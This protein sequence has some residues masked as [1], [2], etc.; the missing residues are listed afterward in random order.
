MI[1]RAMRLAALG[2]TVVAVACAPVE[3]VPSDG[4]LFDTGMLGPVDADGDGFAGADDCD[5]GDASVSPA[6]TAFVSSKVR[7]SSVGSSATA[8]PRRVSSTNPSLASSAVP[9]GTVNA[10][11]V[12]SPEAA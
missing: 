12:V 8:T 11:L 1:A 2:C 6:A 3:K 4:S 7:N 10:A 9:A 5:D